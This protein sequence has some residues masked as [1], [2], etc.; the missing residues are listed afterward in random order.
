M[1]NLLIS[2]PINR[3]CINQ[4][5]QFL[6]GAA[7]YLFVLQGRHNVLDIGS[8]KSRQVDRQGDRSMPSELHCGRDLRRT[9]FMSTSSNAFGRPL[10]AKIAIWSRSRFTA[11][12][13]QTITSPSTTVESWFAVHI[14]RFSKQQ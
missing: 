11:K 9:T 7:R 6:A 8:V 14:G 3:N 4:A 2:V 5:E 1:V 10:M 13:C 12:V